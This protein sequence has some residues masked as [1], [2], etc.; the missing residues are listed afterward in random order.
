MAFTQLVART[1]TILC[2]QA[3]NADNVR[4]SGLDTLDASSRRIVETISRN[5]SEPLATADG[6]EIQTP[7]GHASLF[8]R[9]LASALDVHE[10][11]VRVA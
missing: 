10:V 3:A 8:A 2:R 1:L 5:I 7:P 11:D 4:I 9:M 6:F